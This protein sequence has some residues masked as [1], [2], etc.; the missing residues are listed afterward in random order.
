MYGRCMTQTNLKY[1]VVTNHASESKTFEGTF[2]GFCEFL[3]QHGLDLATLIGPMNN[4]G[5]AIKTGNVDV[6]Y[7]DA[8]TYE[9]LSR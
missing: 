6:R 9:R 3:H 7:E 5:L 2:E 4:G 1:Q 8:S